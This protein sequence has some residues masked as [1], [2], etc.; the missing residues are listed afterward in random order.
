MANLAAALLF[1][2]PHEG[3]WSN[4][5][6]DRGG[7]T[8][9]GITLALAQRYG[10]MTEDDLRNI[11]DADMERIYRAEF[12]RF[13]GIQDQRVAS[14]IMDLCVNFGGGTEIRMVQKIL[15][16]VA[17]GAYGPA[18]EAAVNAQDPDTLIQQISDASVKRYDEIA[19]AHPEDEEF[20]AGWLN[21]AK[22]VPDAA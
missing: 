16:V 14:K 2:L 1:L 19:A 13:D 11:S 7:P 6:N 17:D 9:H 12:W 21:R 18:T 3:G 10:I 20:L 8:M 5:R 4:R 15:G 22:A